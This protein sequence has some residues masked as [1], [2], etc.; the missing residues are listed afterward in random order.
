MVL[1]AGVGTRMRPL[2][3]LRA[4]P[5]L[6]VLNRPLLQ[7]TLERLARH[8]V[9]EAV[10]N[11]HHLAETV[12]EAVGDGSAFGLK[13]RYSRERT[14]LGTAGGPRKVRQLLGDEAVLLVNGDVFFDFDLSRLVARHRASGALATLATKPNPDL[15][16]Y[17]PIITGPDGWVRWLPGHGR[18]RRGSA[19]LFTGVH[20]MEPRL[21][22]RLT[23][24][25]ADSVR[26][27]YA[28]LL[29][30]GGRVLGVR[31]AGPWLDLGRPRL[32]LEAQVRQLGRGASRRA[33]Q[34]LV[35]P[36]ARLA[37]G[38]RLQRS[39]VGAG[40]LVGEGATVARSV[41]WDGARIGAGA[42]V[43]GSV[44]TDAGV[45]GQGEHVSASVVTGGGRYPLS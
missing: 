10:V 13:V 34:C 37:R 17:P 41:L 35:D 32:Y 18:R 1:A 38:A 26:D 14:I 23:A 11:L 8:G 24:G 7:W 28:P 16:A 30:E 3:L 33:D 12:T 4:K 20:V 29:A 27:L 31:V 25:P 21:L 44:V 45:V 40:A 15:R 5:A 43:R 36:T 22:D 9:T 2:T 19:S 42:V 39:V 6:P